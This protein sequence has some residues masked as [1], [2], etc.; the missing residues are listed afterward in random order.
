MPSMMIGRQTLLS[1][2]NYVSSELVASGWSSVTV[3]PRFEGMKIVPS[4]TGASGELV[5]PAVTIVNNGSIDGPWA[6]IGDSEYERTSYFSVLLYAR[7]E[8]QESDLRDFIVQ[9]LYAGDI[10]VY[11]YTSSGY[12]ASGVPVLARLH[13]T[14]IAHRPVHSFSN[15]NV[16]LRYAGVVTFSTLCYVAC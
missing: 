5:L 6:G 16:A 14:D 7:T 1:L 8:G 2:V 3:V 9:R 11:Q 15:P 13:V 4:G 12:P 10:N